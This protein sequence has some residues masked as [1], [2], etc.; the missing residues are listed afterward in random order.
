MSRQA[1]V[2]I[3]VRSLIQ[4]INRKLEERQEMLKSAQGALAVQ[5]VGD[6]YLI[7]GAMNAVL[8][9]HVDPEAFGR[10]LGVLRAYETVEGL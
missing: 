4:R 6:Y 2:P 8:A 3:T 10:E 1:S 9:T 7:D 5:Q